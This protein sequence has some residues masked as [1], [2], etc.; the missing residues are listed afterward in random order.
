MCMAQDQAQRCSGI[1]GTG[2][3]NPF[4]HPFGPLGWFGTASWCAMYC[5]VGK[6]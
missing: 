3:G 5:E 2:E 1:E 6:P 4:A